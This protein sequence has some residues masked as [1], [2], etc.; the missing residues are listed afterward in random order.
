[1]QMP[2]DIT[3]QF[4]PRLRWV[5]AV[6]HQRLGLLGI[7]LLAVIVVALAFEWGI[8]RS[9]RDQL[10][11]RETA[12]L[13]GLRMRPQKTKSMLPTPV[14]SLPA[15]SGFLQELD[16]AY[17]TLTRNGF[18][19]GEVTYQEA[20]D[21]ENRLRRLSVDMPLRGT[22]PALRRA[23]AE[24]EREPG[25]RVEQLQVQRKAIGDETL[26]IRLRFSFLG[27]QS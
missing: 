2:A 16:R 6:Q 21:T 12:V 5:V 18:I 17:A 7:F 19:L 13:Q 26:E 4:L 1:M 9:L 3:R 24:L 23:L 8:L 15:A 25:L 22:Y 20:D 11:V 27:T 14:G 10:A